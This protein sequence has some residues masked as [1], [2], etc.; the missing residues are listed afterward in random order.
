M[1]EK[2]FENLS[3]VVLVGLIVAQ[4]V[5]GKWYLVGQGLYLL[6]N[7]IM[8]TRDFLL[9]R[10]RAD[11]VKDCSCTA[12]TIGLILIA[13]GQERLTKVNLFCY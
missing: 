9:K 5:I 10:P 3:Y 6:C 7:G 8:V 1:N 12:I 4:C 13:I 11:K 2:V